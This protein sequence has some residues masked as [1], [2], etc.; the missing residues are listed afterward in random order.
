MGI[1]AI[2]NFIKNIQDTIL[3]REGYQKTGV[4]TGLLIAVLTNKCFEIKFL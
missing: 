3:R 2:F 4:V 1:S